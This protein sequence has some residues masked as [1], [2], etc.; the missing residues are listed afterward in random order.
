MV[1]DYELLDGE[2]SEVM[3][4]TSIDGEEY[5]KVRGSNFWE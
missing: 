1:F 4:F 3:N 2:N 5:E